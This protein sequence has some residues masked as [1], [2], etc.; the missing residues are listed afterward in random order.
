[1]DYHSRKTKEIR[2]PKVTIPKT[3]LKYRIKILERDFMLVLTQSE[4]TYLK[5]LKTEIAIDNAI[6]KIILKHWGEY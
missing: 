4:M 5:S 6:R 2:V 1:M 3:Y